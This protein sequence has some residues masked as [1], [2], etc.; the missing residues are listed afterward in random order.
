MTTQT[1][2]EALAMPVADALAVLRKWYDTEIHRCNHR[3]SG[4][5][6]LCVE[7]NDAIATLARAVEDGSELLAADLQ[8]DDARRKWHFCDG[9]LDECENRMAEAEERRENAI[10]TARGVGSQQEQ[11]TK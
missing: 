9:T 7:R 3:S 6:P 8:Y 4:K 10:D 11:G 1:P 5:C 2:V